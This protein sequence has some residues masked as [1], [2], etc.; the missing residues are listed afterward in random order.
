[1]DAAHLAPDFWRA[2]WVLVGTAPRAYQ[3]AVIREASRRGRRAAL[4]TQREFQGDWDS[5]A[6]LLPR[7]DAL[8]T[9]SGEVVDWRGDRLP[10]GLAALRAANSRLTCLVTCSRRGALVLHQEQ[11]YRVAACPTLVVNTTGGGD[12][13]AAAWLATLAHSGDCE[14][15]LR[16]ASAAAALAVGG[17]AHT[18]LPRR[19]EIERKLTECGA[20]LRSEAWPAGS[21]E[22]QA[23]LAEEDA[24]CH[25]LVDR[26][27]RRA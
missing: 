13:F 12:A 10:D 3:A 21:A 27:V 9:N 26:R 23:A 18:R 8:F 20:A 14:R 4:S 19:D 7:L 24:H 11:L 1:M 25:R 16:A 6:G 2:D 22:A 15:A 5:L 17:L